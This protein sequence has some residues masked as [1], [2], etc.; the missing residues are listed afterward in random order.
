MFEVEVKFTS[1]RSQL[2]Y[3]GLIRRVR[4]WPG[5]RAAA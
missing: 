2:D 1:A 4:E 3:L 5:V